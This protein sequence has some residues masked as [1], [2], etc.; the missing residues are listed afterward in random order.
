MQTTKVLPEEEQATGVTRKTGITSF[1]TGER[2]KR[3]PAWFYCSGVISK[4]Y[5]HAWTSGVDVL[6]LAAESGAALRRQTRGR[7][8]NGTA[9]DTTFEQRLAALPNRLDIDVKVFPGTEQLVKAL[10]AG[11]RREAN[12]LSWDLNTVTPSGFVDQL[13]KAHTWWHG[14]AAPVDLS[15]PVTLMRTAYAVLEAMSRR[16]GTPGQAHLMALALIGIAERGLQKVRRCGICFRW[17]IPG[18]TYCHEHSQSGA[19]HGALHERDARRQQDSRLK[20]RNPEL[21]NSHGLAP[22]IHPA[23]MPI[24]VGRILWGLRTLDEQK[25]RNALQRAVRASAHLKKVIGPESDRP[26]HELLRQ[27]QARID[28][29]EFDLAAWGPTLQAAHAWLEVQASATGHRGVGVRSRRVMLQACQLAEAGM[30]RQEIAEAID[31]TPT[32]IGLWL[33]RY[34]DPVHP[35]NDL[36]KRL[37]AALALPRPDHRR[38]AD[39]MAQWHAGVL[40][41]LSRHG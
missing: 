20:R 21:T 41:K 35:L 19:A 23:R 4:S 38:R 13:T 10:V 2:R 22:S 18:Q 29:L 28:P 3:L 40:P 37:T 26:D 17:A 30:N 1:D 5:R 9:R 16:L 15:T 8:P 14:V 33:R 7:L 32:A 31:I 27:L 39:R 11:L 25:T 24:V 12:K 34:A 36:A 6:V